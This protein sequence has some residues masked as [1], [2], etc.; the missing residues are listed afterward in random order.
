MNK[1]QFLR[2][3]K[4]FLLM[5]VKYRQGLLDHRDGKPASESMI[6]IMALINWWVPQMQ[7]FD[8]IAKYIHRTK[9][10]NGVREI[11]PKNKKRWQDKFTMLIAESERL[12]Q[13]AHQ[14]ELTYSC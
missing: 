5:V 9:I 1:I 3:C 6:E 2:Q 10:Q 8:R 7:S 12:Q 13:P 11:I 14:L 4:S